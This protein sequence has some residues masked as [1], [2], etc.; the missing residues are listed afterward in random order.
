MEKKFLLL[1]LLLNHG[2]H[3]YQLND[4][5]QQ[6]PGTPISITKSNAYKLLNDM[7]K[8]GWVTH[9]QEQEGNRPQRQVYSV[10]EAGKKTFYRM[11]RENLSTYK[12]PEFP[13]VVGLD[14]LH[15]LP[16]E[17]VI[18]L[19][20]ER[21]KSIRE[22]FQQ[23]DDISVEMRQSHL[24]IDYLHQHYAMEVKWV[25]DALNRLYSSQKM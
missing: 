9:V 5:L 4:M 25:G 22:K 17:E 19:L 7:E 1:G 12:A 11:L 8:D 10:T 20:E 23:L 2:M 13:S 16:V 6:N 18:S 14:F 24:A 21:Q 3:G 15:M